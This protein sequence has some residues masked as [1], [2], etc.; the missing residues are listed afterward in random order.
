MDGIAYRTEKYLH[1]FYQ[2]IWKE[3]KTWETKVHIYIYT[4]IHGSTAL[5][6]WSLFQ[7]LNPIY[8]RYQ[9]ST[10]GISRSQNRYLHIVQYKQNKRKN[11]LASKGI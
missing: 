9:Y 5:W 3:G 7:F 1:N 2:N 4:Y 8:S 11:N 6:T 10:G